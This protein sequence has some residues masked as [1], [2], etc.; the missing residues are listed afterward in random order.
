MLD[1]GLFSWVYGSEATGRY[2]LTPVTD[3]RRTNALAIPV[4]RDLLGALR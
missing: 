4:E 1:F 3:L 2:R